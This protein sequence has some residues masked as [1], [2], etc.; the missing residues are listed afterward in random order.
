VV[1]NPGRRRVS[2][3]E[4]LGRPIMT[5][6]G[7]GEEEEESNDDGDRGHIGFVREKLNHKN[8][9]FRIETW[10]QLVGRLELSRQTLECLGFEWRRQS[11]QNAIDCLKNPPNDSMLVYIDRFFFMKG[12]KQLGRARVLRQEGGPT[13]QSNAELYRSKKISESIM[14]VMCHWSIPRYT[15][16]MNG[17]SI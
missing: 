12:G 1:Q 14:R 2:E 17:F 10:S 11:T 4:L 9:V 8:L 7:E 5:E 6:A 15:I 3:E 13:A 16:H